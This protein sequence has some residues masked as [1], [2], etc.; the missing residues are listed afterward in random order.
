MFHSPPPLS[1]PEDASLTGYVI[2]TNGLRPTKLH[3]DNVF[4][5]GCLNNKMNILRDIV[6]ELGIDVLH[7]TKTHNCK[8]SLTTPS[9]TWS[10]HL[11]DEGN[12]SHK[13]TTF[14]RIAIKGATSDMKVSQVKVIWEKEAIWLITAY[15]PNDLQG[16][17]DTTRVIHEQKHESFGGRR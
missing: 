8:E 15:F 16:T 7:I 11:S 5:Q 4:D 17:I 9:N 3:G 10:C 14:T 1:V 13:A 2:N 6:M 12:K